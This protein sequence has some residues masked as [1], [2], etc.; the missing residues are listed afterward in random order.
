MSRDGGRY[1]T[2]TSDPQLVELGGTT[3]ETARN[4]AESTCQPPTAPASAPLEAAH[5]PISLADTL[6]RA[7]ETASDPAALIAA[8]RSL[9]RDAQSGISPWRHPTLTGSGG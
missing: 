6:L 8:A 9:L 3:P 5:D 2:R 7:A 1:W 4:G